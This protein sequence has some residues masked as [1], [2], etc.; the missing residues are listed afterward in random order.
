MAAPGQEYPAAAATGAEEGESGQQSSSPPTFLSEKD[1]EI[2]FVEEGAG[3][4]GDGKEDDDGDGEA[5][6]EGET[7]E[8]EEE[9]E[10]GGEEVEVEEEKTGE[11]AIDEVAL[12]QV[13]AERGWYV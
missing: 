6:A 11:G 12:A 5:D 2:K 10:E 13:L 9:V 4:K 3:G 1:F 8:I 7:E